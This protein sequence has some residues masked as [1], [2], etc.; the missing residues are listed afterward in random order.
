MI[1]QAD[2]DGGEYVVLPE[3]A[4]QFL[5]REWRDQLQEVVDGTRAVLKAVD[6]ELTSLSKLT[7]SLVTL[8]TLKHIQ[9]RLTAYEF[10]PTMEAFL[11]LDMLTTAF[12]VTYA[13]LQQGGGGSGFGRDALP[14]HL[15][16]IHD[17]IIDLRNR[18]FAHNAGHHSM[19]DAMEIGFSDGDFEIKLGL[20]LG[21]HVGGAREWPELVAFVD[22]LMVD[23]MERIRARLEAKTGQR[24]AMPEG[25]PPER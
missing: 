2:D 20:Q 24:W 14:N 9:S 11:E 3:E 25:P 15:R 6:N 21:F 10:A 5:P 18:R 12:V 8:V 17:G 4:L 23:R 1:D 22:E 7:S 16:P 19:S 13:R